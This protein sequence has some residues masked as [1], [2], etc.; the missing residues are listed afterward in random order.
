MTPTRVTG[1]AAAR[2]AAV[3]L[4]MASR[5]AAWSRFRF[6]TEKASEAESETEPVI[7]SRSRKASARFR[8]F[9]LNQSAA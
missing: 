9:S 2:C 1:T 4:R 8:P 6:F 7:A 5:L 3:I